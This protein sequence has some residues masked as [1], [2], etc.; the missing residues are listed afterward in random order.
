MSFFR[1]ILEDTASLGR[2]LR[3]GWEHV[4]WRLSWWRRRRG[5]TA[6]KAEAEAENVRRSIAAS[7]K[8][9]RE[10]RALI[11]SSAGKCPECGA[12][13]AH[14]RSGGASRALAHYLPF[15]PS[16]SMLLVTSFFALYLVGFLVSV[17][18]DREPGAPEMTPFA[19]LMN[20]DSRALIMTGANVG[21][22]SSGAEPWRLLTAIFL[23]AGIIHLLFNT[24]AIRVIGPLIEELYGPR[25]MFVLYLATGI[26]S[27]VASLWFHGLR[28][29]QVGASGAIFGLIGVGA[30]YGLRRGGSHG[31]MLRK[32][33]MSWAIYGVVMGFL[34]HADNAAHIGGFLA[35]AGLAFVVPDADVHRGPGWER[36]WSVLSAI[37]LVASVGA[38]ALIAY[39]WAGAA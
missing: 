34:L 27:N 9:C 17:R 12:P 15:E 16:V 22:L 29:L 20:L 7:S 13:T 23:H 24:W 14:I 25:K 38:F 30:V 21:R 2:D 39:V 1:Q 11:P 3:R 31:E 28:L 4:K 36:F 6:E 37:G 5:I 32:Q 19:A 35:G 18:L 10:C 26:L 8:M 33:M